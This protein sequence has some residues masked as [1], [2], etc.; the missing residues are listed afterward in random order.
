[1]RFTMEKRLC[2]YAA[3]RIIGNHIYDAGHELI[4][5]DGDPV[6]RDNVIGPNPDHACIHV[7]QGNPIIENN[8]IHDACP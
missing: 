4:D 6:I 2:A 1:M 3:P 5:M 8:D 7:I